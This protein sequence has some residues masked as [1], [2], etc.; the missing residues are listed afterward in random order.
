MKPSL[1]KHTGCDIIDV[2]PGAGVWS[3]AIHDL[4]KPRTHILME[5]D[6]SLYKPLLQPLLDAEGSTYKFIPKS[7][8]VWGH[9]QNVL[10]PQMLPHQEDLNTGDPRLD[11]PND[12]L[13]FIA[14]LG[15]YPKKPYRAFPSITTLVLYQLLGAVRAHSLFQRYGLIRM[16]IWAADEEKSLVLPKTISKR[17]KMSIE[18]EACSDIV[19]V[20]SSTVENTRFQREQHLTL[21]SS[22]AVFKRME[23]AGITMPKNRQGPAQIKAKDLGDQTSDGEAWATRDYYQE[24]Q[25][26]ERRFAA[27]EFERYTTDI[28]FEEP[29]EGEKLK[30]SGRHSPEW[31]RLSRLRGYSARIKK[32]GKSLSAKLAEELEA[33]ESGIASGE[34]EKYVLESI[35]KT[36]KETKEYKRMRALQFKLYSESRR[37]GIFTELFEEFDAIAEMQKKIITLDAADAKDLQLELDQR[38]TDYRNAVEKLLSVDYD[39][40]KLQLDNRRTFENKPPL[41][42]WDRRQ[43]EPLKVN[44]EEFF[45]QHEMCLLDF[46]PKPLW[47]VLRDNFPANYDV[48]DYILSSLFMLSAQSVRQG[49]QSLAPGA[50]EWLIAE[51]PSVTDPERGGNRDLD[52][53][54]VRCLTLEMFQEIMEAWMRWPFR[55]SRFELIKRMGSAV[56]D[57]DDEAGDIK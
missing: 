21:Q 6:S 20:A 15:W 53:M 19:E 27:G 5:P 1:L 49:F 46:Q 47:L 29:A 10:T 41:L 28:E 35:R 14:N 38:T 4:L 31:T 22:H 30:R 45:P 40:F 39:T 48:F 8:T 17:R 7:G 26:Y 11:K 37:V 3:S 56:H 25:D 43:V 32:E 42:C 23:E 16:L 34:I 2:N 24:L 55:P 33:L 50:L 9:L 13:L 57:P 52:L 51:C 18:A 54:N 12:T 36:T 44:P